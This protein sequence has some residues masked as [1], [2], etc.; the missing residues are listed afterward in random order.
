MPR[1]LNRR[2]E[3]FF[4][5]EAPELKQKLITILDAVFRDNHNARRLQPDGTYVRVQPDKNE[6]RFSSQR[7][8]RE[9]VIRE[10]D[11]KEKER[12]ARRKSIFQP[13]TNPDHTEKN[14]MEEG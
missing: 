10:F 2:V 7:F 8:F 11:Q 6:N 3:V 1:N 9:E 13:L 14:Q 4:P 12:A 5:V